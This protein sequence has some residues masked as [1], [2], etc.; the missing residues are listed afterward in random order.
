MTPETLRIYLA[1]AIKPGTPPATQVRI[2]MHG[3]IRLGRWW[4]FKAYEVL[5]RSG[6]FVWA[7][8]VKVYGL[9]IR[10]EDRLENGSASMNWRLF[11][12]FPVVSASGPDVTRSAQGRAAGELV[13]WL[14][15][16]IEGAGEPIAAMIAQARLTLNPEGRL[17]SLVLR[18]WG[19]PAGEKQHAELDF[20]IFAGEERTFGGYTIPTRIRA[21]WHF[22]S[23]RFER[24]GEF[25]QATVDRAVYR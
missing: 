1:H 3:Q 15:S 4:P 2:E 8:T 25:F 13:A 23:P 7:A 18:R 6:D 21:G 19:R 20:G 12:L 24:E 5:R 9:P 10:G 22:G 16:A 14:P 17:R 11:G